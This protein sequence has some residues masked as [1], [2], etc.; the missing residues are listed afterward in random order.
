VKKNRRGRL[1]EVGKDECFE[2]VSPGQQKGL[3][4]KLKV[5]R[6]DA[7]T[8]QSPPNTVLVQNS[9]GGIIRVSGNPE[10]RRIF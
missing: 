5:W 10:I 1:K 7:R 8:P 2:M 4:G 3:T 6:C 9:I